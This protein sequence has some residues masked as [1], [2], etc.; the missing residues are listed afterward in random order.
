MNPAFF[1][2]DHEA[3]DRGEPPVVVHALPYSDETHLSPERFRKLIES[4]D[5]LEF[6]HSLDDQ[7]GGQIE[8]GFHI[9]GFFED[10]WAEAEHLDK[11]FKSD[12]TTRARKMGP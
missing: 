10:G 11:W 3:L 1:L 4:G 12:M 2:F 8:A 6:S 7:I 9:V 5:L